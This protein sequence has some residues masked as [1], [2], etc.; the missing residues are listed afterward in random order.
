MGLSNL[1]A[2]FLS[3]KTDAE[4]I[5]DFLRFAT[6]RRRGQLHVPPARERDNRPELVS[7]NSRTLSLHHQSAPG[8]HP[9]QA[10]EERGRIPAAISRHTR[11]FG[12]GKTSRSSAL[13]TAAKFQSRSGG[14]SR[15]SENL[16]AN[17]AHGI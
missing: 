4:E 15:L 13:P 5:S 17:G 12:A 16:A 2:R 9:H 3:R 7:R 6:E 1:E 14:A 8:A 11:S 10:P